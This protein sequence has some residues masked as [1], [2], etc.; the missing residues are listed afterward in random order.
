MCGIA[1][2]SGKNRF[3]TKISVVKQL[4]FSKD[5][6]KSLKQLINFSLIKRDRKSPPFPVLVGYLGY[7]MIRLMENI[8]LKNALLKI[9]IT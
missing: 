5:P 9:H 4:S 1:G 6:I 8:K 3:D 2:Y 7:P